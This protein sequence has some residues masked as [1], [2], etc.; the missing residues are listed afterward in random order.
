MKNLFDAFGTISK[1]PVPTV[2]KINIKRS[3]IFFPVVGYV[4]SLINFGIYYL[5]KDYI[6]TNILISLIMIVY[7]YLFQYFHFDG[8][9]DLI[10]GFGAQIKTKEERLKI[11]KDSRVGAFALLGGVLY[12]LFL[13][14]LMSNIPE[15]FL[16][17]PVFSRYTMN[18][19]LTISKP[20]RKDGLGKMYFPYPKFYFLLSLI[21]ILP[22][23]YF[24]LQIFLIG[25]ASSIISAVIMNIISNKKIEGVTGDVIGASAI[26]SEVVYLFILNL[27]L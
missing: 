17:A 24:N 21:F 7:F 4:A 23:A 13:F 1:I 14:N 2:K 10:D 20:A 19:L 25:I 18:L 9:V 3:T 11:L 6:P 15:G 16:L 5:L 8:F 22:I 27:F 26:I 12:I